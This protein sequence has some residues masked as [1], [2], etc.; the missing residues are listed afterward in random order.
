MNPLLSYA[1]QTVK[2]TFSFVRK[3]V[4]VITVFSA[5][6]LLFSYFIQKDRPKI[7]QAKIL[8]YQ[9]QQ[10]HLNVEQLSQDISDTGKMQSM[11]YRGWLCLTS[12]EACSDDLKD[13]ED[14]FQNSLFGKVSSWI[15]T[16]YAN[17]PASGM[18]W[19]N[20]SL[21][22]A[23]FIPSTYA[24]TGTGFASIQG[25]MPIWKLFRDISYLLLVIFI[26]VIG[27]MI[28][29]RSNGGGQ[30]A[31]SIESALPRIVIALLMITFSFPIAGF[32]IDLMYGFIAIIVGLL[33]DI[34]NIADYAQSGVA[35]FQGKRSLAEA[36]SEYRY[37]SFGE[38]WPDGGGSFMTTGFALYKILPSVVQTMTNFIIIPAAMA[39]SGNLIEPVRK[40]AESFYNIAILGNS[41]GGL[42]GLIPLGLWV[43]LI[44]FFV[45]YGP[46]IIFGLIIMLTILLFMFRIFFMLLASYIK[47]L[48]YIIF[49]PIIL[50]LS[51]IP[52]NGN[53][54]WWFKNLIGELSTFPTVITIM[55]VGNAILAASNNSP[56]FAALSIFGQG[57]ETTLRLPFLYGMQAE[58][59]N[60]II[61][62]GL[63]L[64]IPDFIKMIKGFIG[65]SESP[66]N[67]GLG[68]YFAGLGIFGAAMG[69]AS[70]VQNTKHTIMGVN[71][72]EP[73]GIFHTLGFNKLFGKK[74]GGTS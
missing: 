40:S 28:M 46:G 37:A 6:I 7:N 43:I 70:S 65:V 62:L 72:R 39:Y 18:V 4:I 8:K 35:N 25:Y 23:G 29:F 20:N 1:L 30:T 13:G 63:V 50:L 58:E 24:A 61:A 54:G 26:L 71:Y 68:T 64:L 67:I 14:N 47:I 38:L 49:S 2:N 31:I 36:I 21:Q 74:K 12:G 48:I 16:P 15:A 57:N 51:V 3:A 69:A 55:I 27:F 9:R 45:V 22:D 59:F 10:I 5:V 17:P 56:E 53:I 19:L 73:Q 34:G 32:L 44:A 60:T 11:M 33:Y 66:L 52:G 41:S 42:T